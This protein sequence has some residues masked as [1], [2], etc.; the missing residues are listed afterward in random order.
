LSF[1]LI[2]R[3]L[4]IVRIVYQIVL[5]SDG[6]DIG[7]DEAVVYVLGL[8]FLANV[9]LLASSLALGEGVTDGSISPGTWDLQFES[10]DLPASRSGRP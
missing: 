1:S 5:L 9:E 6:A 4:Y 2:A 10:I 3:S 8:F 7:T